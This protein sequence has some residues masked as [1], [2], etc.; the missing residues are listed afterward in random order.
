MIREDDTTANPLDRFGDIACDS[1]RGG[2]VDQVLHVRR[3]ILS[4]IRIF[5]PPL[6][7]VRIGGESV[8]DA[9]AMRNVELPGVMGSESHPGSVP[10]VIS[11]AQGNHVIV[12]GVS[13]RHQEREIVRL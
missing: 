11:I 6:A 7:A 5:A 12:T 2:I 3:V 10:T 1:T 9:E 13:P 4:G 8:M